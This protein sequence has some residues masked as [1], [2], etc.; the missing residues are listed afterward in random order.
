MDYA[1]SVNFCPGKILIGSESG[2]LITPQAAPKGHTEREDS[3]PG[4]RARAASRNL[5]S[6]PKKR[7]C[8]S[9]RRGLRAPTRWLRRQ[10]RRHFLSGSRLSLENWSFRMNRIENKLGLSLDVFFA[11]QPPFCSYYNLIAH[12]KESQ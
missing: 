10:K 6:S 9:R 3:I 2:M 7:G 12:K 4:L 5:S 8:R 11:Y 1:S